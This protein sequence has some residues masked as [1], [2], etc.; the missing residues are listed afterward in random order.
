MAAWR[1]HRIRQTDADSLDLRVD[2]GDAR[3]PVSGLAAG[4]HHSVRAVAPNRRVRL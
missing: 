3:S 2:V 4:G 1:R